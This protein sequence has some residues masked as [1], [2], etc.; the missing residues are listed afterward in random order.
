MSYAYHICYEYIYIYIYVHD[1]ASTEAHTISSTPPLINVFSYI[2]IMR[3]R[4]G[5]GRGTHTHQRRQESPRENGRQRFQAQ[6][7]KSVKRDL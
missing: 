2:Y 5:I 3:T 6:I 7:L 1:Q 4:P